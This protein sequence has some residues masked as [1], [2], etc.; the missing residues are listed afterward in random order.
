MQA[1]GDQF[2][3]RTIA[4]RLHGD[5]AQRRPGGVGEGVE[6]RLEADQERVLFVGCR[7]L[8]SRDEA[9]SVGSAQ[10]DGDGRRWVGRPR[11]D[12]HDRIRPDL[13]SVHAELGQPSS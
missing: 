8:P 6:G 11:H 1:A 13:G 4:T 10:H 7:T 5:Q 3:E 12:P 9:R 2:M